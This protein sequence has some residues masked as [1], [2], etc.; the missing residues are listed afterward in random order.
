M[1]GKETNLYWAKESTYVYLFNLENQLV[2]WFV[3]PNTGGQVSNV[4]QQ[5]Q[6][7]TLN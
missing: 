5:R 6:E 4:T 3:V 1:K 7:I 2:I